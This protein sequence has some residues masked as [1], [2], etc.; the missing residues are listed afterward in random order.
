MGSFYK[1]TN[2]ERLIAEYDSWNRT[3]QWWT[4][5]RYSII[6]YLIQRFHYKTYLEIGIANG[7][8]F[9]NINIQYKDGVDP[10]SSIFTKFTMTSDEFFKQLDTHKKYDIIFI[11]GL[12]HDY[13]VYTDIINSLNHLSDNGMILCHDMNPPVEICQEKDMRVGYWNGD[14]W[15]A[16]AQLRSEQSDLEMYTIDTDWGIGII[17]RGKQALINIPEKLDYQYLEQ[18]RT[19]I[20]NLISMDDFYNKFKPDQL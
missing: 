17:Q 8:C 13:Q 7:E 3:F 9:N 5:Y 14:C 18:N 4:T 10:V 15:K 12:H 11:D 16:F 19:H 1:M 2:Q 20:L 6:N